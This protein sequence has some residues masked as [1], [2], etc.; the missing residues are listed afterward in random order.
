MDETNSI[1]IS[2]DA[3]KLKQNPCC[4]IVMPISAI[5]GC[6]AEHWLEVRTIIMSAVEVAEFDGRLVSEA[7]DVGSIH[8]R[9]IQNLYEDPIVVCDVSGKNSNVMFELGM[10]LAF[11]KPTI[12]VKDDKTSYSFDT[13][14]IEHLEYP[15]DLRYSKIN[16]F[17]EKL[18]YKI[19]ATYKAS[20][21]NASYTTFLKHFGEF[22]VATIDKKEV[23]PDEYIMEELKSLR[24]EMRKI[25]RSYDRGPPRFNDKL[26]SRFGEGLCLKGLPMDAIRQYISEIS[27]AAHYESIEMIEISPDHKHLF[28]QCSPKELAYVESVL[29][30]YRKKYSDEIGGLES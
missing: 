20:Q 6:S 24:Y 19:Q 30:E 2:T 4:G 5:D 9:I 7:D 10:R 27:S 29:N 16:E 17:K 1:S 14:S 23:T 21:S 13:S 8:K 25:A 28:V 15:R 3:S 26:R 11:D 12:I 22:T 18:A